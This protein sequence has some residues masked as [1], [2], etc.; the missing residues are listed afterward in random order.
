MPLAAAMQQLHLC[1]L[2]AAYLQ[3]QTPFHFRFVLYVAKLLL[4]THPPAWITNAVRFHEH[5]N[6]RGLAEA[7]WISEQVVGDRREVPDV[8]AVNHVNIGVTLRLRQ[9]ET[10]DLERLYIRQGRL[11]R[12]GQLAGTEAQ[13][14]GKLW[15]HGK[16][17]KRVGSP[18]KYD[19]FRDG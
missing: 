10:Q 14:L 19:T 18:S 13:A 17:D 4:I 8:C 7:V 15:R 11:T 5:S 9:A 1:I 3:Q 12:E 16:P 6:E 2:V